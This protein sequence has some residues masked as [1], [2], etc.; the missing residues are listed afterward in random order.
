MGR[1]W[2][3]WKRTG[4]WCLGLKTSVGKLGDK[5]LRVRDQELGTEV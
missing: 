5:E 1:A 3:M 4:D 2:E